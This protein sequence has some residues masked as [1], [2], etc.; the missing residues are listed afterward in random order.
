MKDNGKLA[1]CK[2]LD[3]GREMRRLFPIFAEPSEQSSVRPL[4]MHYL[5]SAASSQKPKVVID[6]LCEYL[7]FQHA[8]IHRGA[9]ALS[10]EAT[11]SY[12]KARGKIA[13]HINAKLS[14]EVV[15]TKGATESI[16]LV[17]YA[18]E[19]YFREGDT[20]LLTLL[21]HHSNIVPWQLLAKRKGLR[22]EFADISD[23]ASLNVLDF[24]EKIERIRPK[25]CSFA[26]V[27]NSF[28][29]VLPI[30]ELI[31]LCHGVGAKVMVDAAQSIAHMK[32]DVQ[33]LR[34]D[35]LVFS[36]H[37][38]YGPTGIGALYVQGDMYQ[39]MQPFQGGGDMI[40]AVTVDG[41]TWAEP[42]QKFEAGTPPIA[43]AIALGAAVDFMAG[44]GIEEVAQYENEL[45]SRALQLL[46]KE[47]GVTLYGPAALDCGEQAS[48]IAFNVHGVH[49]HDL[50]SIADSLNVQI[51]AG[52][53]CAMPA[54]AR[55]GLQ[56]TA[57]ASIGMYSCLDDFEALCE[58]I[59]RSINV[60]R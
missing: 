26:H 25:F 4:P 41:S 29:S 43:E 1:A 11:K 47:K 19:N 44:I 6:R 15:F 37:K 59:R 2:S 53:H 3:S 18:L 16:N 45:L 27:A 9:Y 14:S 30:A 10:G 8:N 50:A 13:E 57:R 56:S 28:G 5:D 42:P 54:L 21:E 7:S 39:H 60:F 17:C 34:C 35:F 40:S 55:L 32:I 51:R 12:E 36:G 23:D 24:K 48:I 49:P 46:R 58:A 20:I 38:M 31:D 52:H 33:A 22:L